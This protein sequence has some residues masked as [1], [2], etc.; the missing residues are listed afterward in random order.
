MN[1]IEKWLGDVRSEEFLQGRFDMHVHTTT[2]D[3]LWSPTE[4]VRLAKERGLSGLAITDHDTLDG[5]AEAAEAAEKFG[6]KLIFGV[7]L[8]TEVTE[9]DEPYEVHM[10]GYFPGLDLPDAPQLL[11]R[12]REQQQS[13][14]G[15]GLKMV[16]KLA[17]LGMPL[18]TG[19]LQEYAENGSVGRGLIARKMLEAGYVQTRE[20]VFSKWL[21][22]GCPAYV[23][24]QRLQP[25]EALRLVQ[26]SGGMAV[27]AH[28]A[29]A[30]HDEL[31]PQLAAA[32]LNG[33]ECRHPDQPAGALQEHYLQL[34]ASLGLSV[35]GGS[36]CHDSG[37]GDFT[38]SGAELLKLFKIK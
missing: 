21:G 12:L 20:E 7:E 8:S 14:R 22:Q 27:M 37:L 1:N 25:M 18:D 10:L 31:V 26:A 17:E 33:L 36:D 28:P 6:V 4:I 38:T 9:A 5:L 24:H 2:S 11:A 16:E 19:F 34:A 35:T 3:G 13:R 15:R 30:A 29:Q 23:P 32:G